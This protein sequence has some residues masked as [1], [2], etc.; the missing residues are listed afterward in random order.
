MA[1]K[2]SMRAPK[3]VVVKRGIVKKKSKINK[4]QHVTK[5]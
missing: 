2:V 5:F 4:A 3:N 1:L